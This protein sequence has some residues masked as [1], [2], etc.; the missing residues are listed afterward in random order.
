M[1]SAWYSACFRGVD[2]VMPGIAELAAVMMQGA[3]RRIENTASNISNIATPGY[4]AQRIFTQVLDARSALPQ[5]S[6]A[7]NRAPEGVALKATGNPL[8]LAVDQSVVLLMRAGDRLVET[9]SAQL[10]RDGDGRLTDHQGRILQSAGGG[11]LS[12]GEGSPKILQDGTVLING[13]A[14]ARIGMFVPGSASNSGG[15]AAGRNAVPEP[16]TSGLLRQGMIAP[17]N[18]DAAAEM[19]ELNRASRMAETGA[20]VFQ[21]YDD[22]VS[23]AAS[24]LGDVRK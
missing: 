11:D 4:R 3:Q 10:K 13:Q 22:L 18:V 2:A 7:S 6:V 19:I 14:E 1:N 8:D 15:D 24:Q 9:R 5:S 12:I 21:L 20:K 16:A 17:A 23:K